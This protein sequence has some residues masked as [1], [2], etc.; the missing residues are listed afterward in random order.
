MTNAAISLHDVDLSDPD[1]YV[2]AVPYE[3]FA[4]LRR[5]A[6][7][8]LNRRPNGR[9]FWALTRYADIRMVHR[10]AATFSSEIGG[11]MLDE[12]TREQ[13][14]ARKSMLDMDP[15]RHDELRAPL[16]RRFTPRTVTVWDDR[17]REVARDLLDRALERGE[18]D[19]VEHVSSLMPMRVFSEVM[20][21]PEEDQQHVVTLG[22]QFVGRDDPDWELPPEKQDPM[23]PFGNPAA[24]EMFDIGRR[25]GAARRED[26]RDDLVS[27]LVAAPMTD[28]EYDIY[29]LLLAVA[30]NETTRHSIS[31][32]LQA[33]LEHRDQLERLREDPSLFKTATEEILRW[34]TPVLQFSRTATRDVEISGT[35]IAAGD[36]VT[37][38]YVSG[39]R[40]EEVFTD[41]D[42]FDVGRS[43]NPHMSFGPGG[44]HHCLGAHLA[45]LEIRILFEELLKA[46]VE[47][48]LAGPVDRLRSNFTNAI[49]RLPV[50]VISAGQREP[51]SAGGELGDTRSVVAEDGAADRVLERGGPVLRDPVEPVHRPERPS[52][53]WRRCSPC[54]SRPARRAR[55]CA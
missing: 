11:L 26:P 15:P 52:R 24:Q 6:P 13:L 55:S 33:L 9:P 50:R 28:H 51:R 53:R 43:P 3:L 17:V 49:K 21:I 31:F 36:K 27:A 22:N 1:L 29:F 16:N 39:N 12:L 20:G 38:W 48:E 2:E 34:A 30:G 44:I 10:D 4:R 5:E 23:M 19:F 37:S 32:G 42:V 54:P 14:D 47:L 7:V 41:P 45:R 18:F 8:H 46:P 40:D 25:L 35:Q